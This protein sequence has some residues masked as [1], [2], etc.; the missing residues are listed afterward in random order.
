MSLEEIQALKLG[1][2]VHIFYAKD[3][4]PEYVRSNFEHEVVEFRDEV[5]LTRGGDTVWD[6]D[7]KDYDPPV[8]AIDTCRG[9]AYFRKIEDSDGA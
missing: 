5:I 2:R 4:N 1:D 6:W 3:D 9:Y 8:R 7:V